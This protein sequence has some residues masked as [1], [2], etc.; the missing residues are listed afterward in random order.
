MNFINTILGTPLSLIIDLL[1]RIT[2]SYGLAIILFAVVVRAILFPLITVAHNNSIRFLR[3]YPELERMKIRY[4]GD[5]EKLGEEQ[6]QLFK[7]A[8]Y[9]PIMGI[10][11]LLLQLVIIVGVM[12]VLL[13]PPAVDLMFLGLE[14]DVVP[15]I[16]NP[17]A[18][19]IIPVLSGL[20]ATAFCL[21]QN[22]ISPAMLS[23]SKRTNLGMT[24]F[25]VALSIYFGVVLPVGVGIYWTM[26]NLMGIVVV[27]LLDV[28]YNPK[29]LA[30]EALAYI[31]AN[32]KSPEELREQR[33]IEKQLSIRE[34]ADI[35]RF[36][37]ADKKLVFY[38]I[39]SGQYR[40]YKTIIDYIINNSD[41]EIHYLTNDPN[42]ALFNE[43]HSQIKPYYV[44]QK[45]MITLMLKLNTDVLVT[46]VPDLQSFHFKR[47]IVREDI[48]YIFTFHSLTS[49]HLVYKEKAFDHFDSI[50]CVGSHQVTELRRREET[51]KLP[52]KQLIKVGYS[53]Y[54]QI[55][56]AYEQLDK[57]ANG[58][59]KILIAPS[60]QADNI[61]DICIEKMLESLGG[62]S[63][64]ITVRPHPQYI[65]LYPERI[66]ELVARFSSVR[67]S[68]EKGSVR[69]ELD[70]LGNES[71][72]TA[73]LL[74][75]DWSTIGYEYAYCTLKPCLFINTP[76]K[77]MNPNY[78]LYGIEPLDIT[79]RDAVGGSID[80][81]DINSTLLDSI[82]KL[83]NEKDSYSKQIEEI[84]SQYIYYP[85]RSGEAGGKYILKQLE[86]K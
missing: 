10:I 19:L 73:D 27:L 47:S 62:S 38:A 67:S 25:I 76:M 33:A 7:E 52:K 5:K 22:K 37:V 59:P 31:E 56:T 60:W 48:E 86:K 26:G 82:K 28:I 21:V 77:V 6:Y 23:Q 15:S 80:V 85:G 72:Y 74:I 66:E 4:A 50:F 8:K 40:F 24:I 18:T 14:L 54:D 45:K 79:L 42:D 84:V 63:Y 61:L 36:K 71:I 83:L 29:K 9:S 78:K 34:I 64:D 81:E 11:P 2:D 30:P 41:I 32:R 1:Y 46:T 69:F 57:Q 17:S 70:F 68:Q 43:H 12:Q 53:V 51:A 35:S 39:S 49:A 65:K 16:V 3:L 55:K 13:D 75:T 58:I 44:G 20:A